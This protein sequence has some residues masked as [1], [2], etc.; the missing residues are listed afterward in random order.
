M[1]GEVDTKELALVD[2]DT[3]RVPV[4][5][6]DTEIE[7]EMV[8]VLDEVGDW[9]EDLE[10]LGVVEMEMVVETVRVALEEALGEREVDRVI[11]GDL[12]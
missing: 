4:M 2:C 5:V 12:D 10:G 3:D 9:E 1:E 11:L 7:E 8:T 6:W